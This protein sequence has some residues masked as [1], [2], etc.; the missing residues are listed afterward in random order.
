M[1]PWLLSALWTQDT[2]KPR[3]VKPTQQSTNPLKD[4]HELLAA[5]FVFLSLRIYRQTWEK[6]T[7][8]VSCWI[9]LEGGKC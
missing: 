7:L 3:D 1:Q 5:V 6:P 2:K 8:G 4:Q 9:S